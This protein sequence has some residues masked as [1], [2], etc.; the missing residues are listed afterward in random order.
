MN[1]LR[2]LLRIAIVNRGEAAMRCLRALKQLRA[3][4]GTELVGIALYT[5]VDRDSPFVR[6]ADEAY[7]LTTKGGAVAAYLDHELI[8]ATLLR[9]RADAVWPGWGF[10]A[11]DPRFA[12]RLAAAGIAFLGPSGD[13]MRSLGDKISAKLLAEEA[14]VPVAA[15][16]GGAVADEAEATAAADA[17]GYPLVI[18]ATAGGGGRGIRVVN[19]P[20][21]LAAAFRSATQEA[22]AAFGDGRCFLERKVSGGRHIEVQ[23]AGDRHGH[24]LAVGVRDCSAQRRHQKVIEEAPAPGFSAARLE[25]VQAAAVRLARRVGYVGVGTVEFLASAT[26]VCFLEVNPRLQVEHGV[27]EAVTGVDLVEWQIRIARGERL[28]ERVPPPHG[29]A[30]EARVCAE[31][32]D[33]GFLPAPGTVARFNPPLGAGV[34]VDTGVVLGSRVPPDFDSLIAKV[35]VTGQNRDE[36]CAKLATELRDFELVLR[37]GTTNKGYLIEVL[38]DPEFRAAGIDTGWL[39][40]WTHE[41]PERDRLAT[42][43]LIVAAIIAYQRAR[44]DARRNFFAEA[45]TTGSSRV[46]T[47]LGQRVDLGYRG[48]QYRLN[49]YA[50][51][52]WKYR[53]QL[54]GS[55]IAATMQEEGDHGGRLV[56]RGKYHRVLYDVTEADLRVEVDGRS[57]R[58]GRQTAGRVTAGTPAIVV[59][60]NVRVGDHVTSGQPIGLLEAMKMEI[61]F[62]APVTGTVKEVLVQKGRQVAAGDVLLVIDPGDKGADGAEG[63]RLELPD[64]SD[65]LDLFFA[66]GHAA[67][68]PL[69]FAQAD[70]AEPEARRAAVEAVRDEIRRVLLGYDADPDRGEQLAAF[71]E[72]ELPADLSVEFRRELAEI[73]HELTVFVDVE[74]LF[75]RTP[76][77]AASGLAAPS[78]NARLRMFVRRIRANGAGISSEF[79]TLLER[80]LRHYGVSGLTH[81]DALERA[82]LRLFAS[83][84][85]PLLRRRLVMGVIRRLVALAS[86]G[87]DL[88]AD[89]GLSKT[90]SL[91]NRLRG[92]VPDAVADAAVGAEYMIYQRPE[93]DTRAERT[94]QQLDTWLSAAERDP[95]TL[96]ADILLRFAEAPRRVFDRVGRWISDPDLGRR[97]IALGAHL[98]RLYTPFAPSS[99]PPEIDAAAG[100]E[101][102]TLRDGRVVLGG[103]ARAAEMAETVSSLLKVARES[104]NGTVGGVDAIE[105]FVPTD[106]ELPEPVIEAL[107]ASLAT[108]GA[109][110]KRLTLC[111]L[112]AGA[113]PRHRTF[114]H[115]GSG[116][117]IERTDLFGLHPETAR[118]IDLDRM[119]GFELEPL[120]GA[121]GIYC[122]YG[123]SRAVRGDERVFVI[124]EVRGRADSPEASR[125]VPAFERAFYETARRL[126]D[127]LA[128][129]DPGRRMRWNRITIV[130]WP[131]MVLE[132]KIA[133]MLARRLAPATRHLGLE[134]TVVR[135]NLLPGRNADGGAKA[136][137][138]VFSDL[139]GNRMEI[140]WREPHHDPLRPATDYERKVVEARRRLLVYPYEIVRMLTGRDRETGQ[141]S[142]TLSANIPEGTFEEYD[143]DPSSSAPRA[144]SVAGRPYG[145]NHAAVVFGIVSTPTQ[146]VPEGMRRVLVLSDPTR[147][148]GALAA[149]ECDRLVAA[150]DLAERLGLPVEWVP[151]SSGARIAMDSGTENLDATARVVRRIVTFTNAGGVIHLVIYGVN[152]GAQ[153]YFDALATMGLKTRGALIMTPQGSMVLTGRAALE[154][155]GSVSAEDEVAIGG[156]ERI[157]G[158]N[159]E[160]Q[161]YA[162]DLGE[163]FWTLYEHYRY[164]YVVPGESRPRSQ[165]TNDGSDRDVREFASAKEPDHEFETIGEVFDDATNPGRRRP[166]SMRALMSGVIDQDGGHLER[167]RA[168][169]GAETAVVWDAHVG[170]HPVCMIGIES[171]NVTREGFRPA[172]GPASWNGGTLFPLSSKKL[173]RALN[174]ASG[175]RPVVLL[176][177]L[178]GFDGSPESMRKLQLE[179]GAEI[180]RAVVTFKGPI[181]FVVVSRYHGGAYVVFSRS[182]NDQLRASAL[183]GAYASVIGGAPAAAVVFSREVRARALKQPR[184]ET[185]RRAL[186]ARSSAERRE[187]YERALAEVTL[188]EQA[189]M[190]AEFDAIHSVSRALDVGSLESILDPADLRAYL[191]REL[192][193]VLGEGAASDARASVS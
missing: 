83:Q 102:M 128:I 54:E 87:I 17:I 150:I 106:D 144:V 26:E 122:F 64:E 146:K 178:S 141:A 95:A 9:V 142:A 120:E 78:N 75:V 35:I 114:V 191:I 85:T 20:G 134:K 2:P 182:L 61:G 42:Q 157:M 8:V 98:R 49:V 56:Y 143:L 156:F 69:D 174:A 71:L 38:E 55:T 50:I 32:P 186:T 79:L 125:Y 138:I 48:E 70:R 185:L 165:P 147:D 67:G 63:R 12:D 129:R 13:T 27:T 105:L 58:F 94:T 84:T 28:P 97:G 47:S 103:V 82:T 25:E 52:G 23:I 60:V 14:G 101:R 6:L 107:L 193:R 117:V 15:W 89:T 176:A 100:F 124:A 74:R 184:I 73:R 179:Y 159:G 80:A 183:S 51:G 153:S 96:P 167:W 163:A 5:E 145:E 121:E 29:W 68:G 16:S 133:E 104:S 86:S 149:P 177:N 45:A 123:R 11:E 109:V 116:R 21:E 155:S 3:R 24:V 132:P 130:V 139:T 170:G 140:L 118:R 168:W 37:G 46:P 148:M 81:G 30:I 172:D 93:I 4:E 113:P 127:I 65:P 36:A 62:T 166:F 72:A 162:P 190:A 135:L 187:V 40:R 108:A 91:V 59:A 18:K 160:A 44:L 188:E 173:A 181:Y 33:E 161:Y 53:L 99:L 90:L 171:R 19:A 57:Y 164:T 41:R 7:R 43:A 76:E 31:D 126:R 151:V 92:V 77:L 137:E 189:K 112:P 34:R 115:S 1:A 66:G 192:A 110:A 136:V 158:P 111:E 175:N 180:A 10:V 119:R 169:V 152:V 22:K 88:A 39:D 131:E 154:A